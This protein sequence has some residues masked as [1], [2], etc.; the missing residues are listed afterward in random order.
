MERLILVGLG[1]VV[2]VAL[3]L[4]IVVRGMAARTFERWR[5]AELGRIRKEA[6]TLAQRE[7]AVAL[8]AWKRSSETTIRV[9]AVNRSHAV[10][11]GKVTEHLAPY[12]GEFPFNP[13]D[14]RFIGSPIDLVVF[15]GLDDERVTEVVLVEIKSGG[16]ALS[17]R[18]RQ[19]RDAVTAGR[20]RWL[21][22]R[23]P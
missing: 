9:D 18:E 5:A 19:V 7:A 14:V 12:L 17:K 23:L 16:S 10:V 8:E 6:E 21:E 15:D 13:R 22:W 11:R 4:V 1:G 3:V 2:I 20:V